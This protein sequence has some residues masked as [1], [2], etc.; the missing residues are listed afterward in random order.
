MRSPKQAHDAA[1]ALLHRAKT[2]P[3]DAKVLAQLGATLTPARWTP[4]PAI[5][6]E[7][8]QRLA[9]RDSLLALRTQV[10]NQHHARLHE[11]RVVVAVEASQTALIAHLTRQIAAIERELAEVIATDHAWTASIV[12]LQSIPGVGVITATWLVPPSTVGQTPHSDFRVARVGLCA[13]APANRNSRITDSA[14]LTVSNPALYHDVL[15]H[16]VPGVLVAHTLW[17]GRPL[18]PDPL[19]ALPLTLTL[20]LSG[21][22]YTYPNLT[23]DP[24]GF[25]TVTVGTLPSGVYSWGRRDCSIW[26]AVAP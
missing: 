17:Q 10:S 18:Q 26:P 16:I 3:L 9:W 15:V 1:C 25:V 21:T 22:Q 12:R 24:A 6:Q 5:Y 2:D 23:T 13:V 7:L 14:N 19:Q 4:P 11:A 20:T 8:Q